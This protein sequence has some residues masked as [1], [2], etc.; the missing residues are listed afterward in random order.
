MRQA[1]RHRAAAHARGV[2]MQAM[3]RA[4]DASGQASATLAPE[5]QI[6]LLYEGAIRRI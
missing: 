2:D 5:Q 6:L 3:R 1:Q 4:I